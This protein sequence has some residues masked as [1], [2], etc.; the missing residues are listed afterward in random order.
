MISDSLEIQYVVQLKISRQ[1][2]GF[3]L[4]ENRSRNQRFIKQISKVNK[5]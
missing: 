4:T 2:A 5:I 3:I 1:I